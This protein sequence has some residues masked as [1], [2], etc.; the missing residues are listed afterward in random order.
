MG[1]SEADAKRYGPIDAAAL[2]RDIDA[3]RRTAISAAE[4]IMHTVLGY[5]PD[6]PGDARTI[7]SR[8]LTWLARDVVRDRSIR[9]SRP[10]SLPPA[11]RGGTIRRSIR[12]QRALIDLRS[13]GDR[14]PRLRGLPPSAAATVAGGDDRA[15]RH[16]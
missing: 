12:Q 7:R 2:R 11:A 10:V 6:E 8:I 15:S 1:D 9:K 13:T 3:E 16:R 5:M 4:A 14:P